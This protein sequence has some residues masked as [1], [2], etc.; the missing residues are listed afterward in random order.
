LKPKQKR[1]AT[2]AGITLS[3]DKSPLIISFLKFNTMNIEKKIFIL[4][5]LKNKIYVGI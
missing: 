4:N 2:G 3:V 5:L 1:W